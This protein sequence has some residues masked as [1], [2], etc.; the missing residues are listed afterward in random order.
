MNFLVLV[1]QQQEEIQIVDESNLNLNKHSVRNIISIRGANYSTQAIE[2][3]VTQ[4]HPSLRQNA[5]VAF[6]VEVNYQERL[7]V[8]QEVKRTYSRIL[9]VDEVIPAIRFAV[10]E[11]HGLQIYAVVLL[12]A[13]SL[14]K[15]SDGK[16][17]RQTCQK[18]FLNASLNAIHTWTVNPQQDL[19]QLQA[20]VDALLE[21]IQMSQQA[22]FKV[23]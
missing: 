8:I 2:K 23:S 7:V 12:K 3:T 9:N 4:S 17:D 1:N 19:Q 13:T 21:N 16:I 10:L 14:P 15:D 11:E 22:Q 18:I 6:T 5:G 20:D